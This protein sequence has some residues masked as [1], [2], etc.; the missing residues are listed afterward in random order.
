MRA[1]KPTANDFREMQKAVE[2]LTAYDLGVE[3]SDFSI[4]LELVNNANHAKL[5]RLLVQFSWLMLE[6]MD[7]R[8]YDKHQVLAEHGLNLAVTAES[9]EK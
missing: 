3:E 6:A 8:G 7:Q 5:T 9:L 1:R 4:Y 2:I